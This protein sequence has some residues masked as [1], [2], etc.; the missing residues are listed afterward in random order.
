[1]IIQMKQVQIIGLKKNTQKVI[2]LLHQMGILQIEDVRNLTDIS[3][4]SYSPGE[5]QRQKREDTGKLLTLIN[6]QTEILQKYFDGHNQPHQTPGEHD[7]VTIQT[8]IDQLAGQIQQ[9]TRDAKKIEADLD[10]LPKYV[11]TLRKILPRL[12]PSVRLPDRSLLIGIM[13][14]GEGKLR[15][16]LVKHLQEVAAGNY[17]FSVLP[18]EDD[19][20]A[21]Q[22]V[23]PASSAH[24]IEKLFE[25]EGITRFSIPDEYVKIP[26]EKVLDDLNHQITHT[27][28]AKKTNQQHFR[29]LAIQWFA[30]LE[31]D[32]LICQDVL[33][34][35]EILDKVGATE[36]TFVILGWI[37]K[38]DV[39]RLQKA[40]D[41]EVGK[42]VWLDVLPTTI[43]MTSATPVEMRNPPLIQPYE[44]LVRM[45]AI[46]RYDDI[47][48]STLTAIFMPMFFGMMVGDIGYGILLFVLAFFLVRTMADGFWKDVVKVL[49]A[50]S[51]WTV[52]FGFLYGE[53]FSDLGKTLGLRAIL[54]DRLQPSNLLPLMGIFIGVGVL[55]ITL[56]LTVGVVNAIKHKNKA[57]LLERGGMLIGLIG[58]VSLIGVLTHILPLALEIPSGLVVIAGIVVLGISF[59]KTGV[60]IGPIEMVGLIG[61]IL[62]YL[63]LAAV[64]LA[65]VYLGL[66]A[67]R[68]VG[69]LG[70]VA[71]G[72][73]AAVIIHA[74]NLIMAGFSPMI[75]SLRLHYV[76]FFQK[77]YEG[78]Q[79]PFMPFKSRIHAD[80]K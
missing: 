2:H 5:Q 73:V 53:F 32:T 69:K 35:F 15:D 16:V 34:E 62:S 65:S 21:V 48:P 41:D 42:E 49:R 19:A 25:K 39:E 17:D 37:P 30:T 1:M 33:E 47:D 43:E 10:T 3:L 74:L 38:E 64:G 36:Q 54:I 61:N 23:I 60:V 57:H 8:Q 18:M 26:P 58:M 80:S 44:T 12:S 45:R 76:E 55:H 13:A 20:E 11:N 71:I 59:G 77:F 70:S 6:G 50:G 40:L 68:L 52:L 78:G 79:N 28:Q 14:R 24:D 4:Q 31:E 75:H 51:L 56:G 66:V 63:R 22:I 9:L 27:E 46:P 7:L 72:L 29:N 67:N